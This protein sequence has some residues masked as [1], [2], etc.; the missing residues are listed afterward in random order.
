VLTWKRKTLGC[1]EYGSRLERSL[2][3]ADV[4]AEADE[5]LRAHVRG[6][7]P[8]REAL[9]TAVLASQ[10][11][12]DAQRPRRVSSEAFVTRV[13]ATI[14]EQE[15]RLAGPGSIWRPLELLASRV[16]LFAAVLLLGLSVYLA[17]FAPPRVT[18]A[19][20]GQTDIGAGLPER[21]TL[22]AN[23]DEVLMSL[24]EMNGGL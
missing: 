13:M 15:A 3:A 2:T 4:N 14:R 7:T 22:P 11:V 21:P 20:T 10:L 6:C 23:E 24:A 1:T 16:A 19:T 5:D 8:C 12:R 18:V 9:E 17:E